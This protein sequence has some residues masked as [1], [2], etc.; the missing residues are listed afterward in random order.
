MTEATFY[1]AINMNELRLEKYIDYVI[2]LLHNSGLE[3]S[4]FQE[5]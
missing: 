1:F 4:F 5:A 2:T 3:A